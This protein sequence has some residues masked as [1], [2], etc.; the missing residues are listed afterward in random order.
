MSDFD[1]V[2]IA[3]VG[4]GS[5]A[6]GGYQPR[7]LAYPN[8]VKLVGY[9]DQYRAGAEELQKVA[10]S[11]KVYATLDEVLADPNVEAVL[12]LTTVN[13]HY[14]VSLK[15]LKA[16]KHVYSEKPVSITT[17]EADELIREA[18]SRK[19]KLA[20]APSSPLGYEQ[21]NVWARIRAGEI[22]TPHTVIGKFACTRL[23]CWHSNADVFMTNGMSVV[24]DA[25]PYPLSC[26]TTFFGPVKRVF[27]FARIVIPDRTLQ[28]GNRQG[29]AFKPTIPD[30]V[31]GLLEFHSGIRGFILAGWSGQSEVPPLE[32]AGTEGAFALNPHND[33]AGIR[34]L[35]AKT[36]E[37]QKVPSPPKSFP[38]ALDWGKGVV[39]FA[40]AIRRDRLPR[41]SGYQARH[42]VEIAERLNEASATNQ[43]IEMKTTFPSPE[44]IGEVAP[45]E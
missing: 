9:Y 31:M 27:G 2:R 8:R 3:V 23:E 1:P 20:C 36:H 13:G 43:V 41:C 5:I 45:W 35:S 29:T 10:G 39:D 7:C 37:Q 30:H 12:N 40:D 44:P 11:G 32:I 28:V 21:Q 19:L 14:P 16:G 17:A 18:E 42:I 33:G 15:A 6:K 26:M 25:T 38:N 24:A 22:G 4:C 34:F